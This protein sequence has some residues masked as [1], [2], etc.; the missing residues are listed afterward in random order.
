MI[1]YFI[2]MYYG[3]NFSAIYFLN[4]EPNNSFAC[5]IKIYNLHFLIYIIFEMVGFDYFKIVFL[6]ALLY[7]LLYIIYE[8]FY[9]RNIFFS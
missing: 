7:I 4:L 1:I 5:I 9:F 8:F 2:C 3:Y 6:F